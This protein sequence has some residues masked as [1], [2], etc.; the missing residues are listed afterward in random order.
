MKLTTINKKIGLTLAG[1]ILTA[2]V[3]MVFSY[4]VQIAHALVA[5]YQP[6]TNIATTT[7]YQT[8]ALAS[9][10]SFA[11]TTV[12]TDGAEQLTLLVMVGSSTTPPTLSWRVQYSSDG[13]DWYDEDMLLGVNSTSTAHVRD[14]AIH[15]WAYSSTTANQTIVNGSNS[16][17]FITKRIVIPNLDT[18]YTRIVWHN[19]AGG[20]LLLNV[21]PSL[22]NEYVLPK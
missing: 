6:N 8:F 20:N 22:K 18:T 1:I 5:R 14:G 21:R 17:K 9:A 13:I 4:R 12:Q 11:T 16:V 7:A 10:G 15:T 3:L 19:G 2:V